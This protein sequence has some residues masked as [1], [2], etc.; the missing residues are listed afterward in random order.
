MSAATAI[1]GNTAGTLLTRFFGPGRADDRHAVETLRATADRDLR[2]RPDP[3][4]RGGKGRK[5]VTATLKAVH[6]MRPAP[7]GII[8]CSGAQSWAS[9]ST[10]LLRDREQ[11]G[12]TALF[13]DVLPARRRRASPVQFRNGRKEA[14]MS[15]RDSAKRRQRN[16]ARYH[17]RVA[18]RR[19]RGLCVKCGKRLPAPER[20]IC[21][22]C[23][24]KA[25][26]AERARAERLRAEGKPVR[27]PEARRRA[28]RERGRRQH[29][30]RR[31]AGLCVKCGRAPALP[32][33]SQCEPC[34][35]RRLAA[36]RARHARAR[37]EGRPRRDPESARRGERERGRQR[38]AE[39]RAAGV[40]IRCGNV[41][42]QE[43]RS[44]CEP[45]RDDRRAAKRARRA[46]R[47]AAGLCETCATPVTGGAACC[48]PLR[49]RPE[50]AAPARSGGGARG[51]PPALCRAARPGR[52]H[53]LRQAGQRGGPVSS[54]PR[55]P[56]APATTPAGPPG[57]ASSAARPPSAARPTARPA[58]PPRPGARTARPGTRPGAGTTP[59][60]GRRAAAS[61]AASR[62]RALHAA[63][64]APPSTQPSATV[65][66]R[67]PPGAGAMPNGGRG[68]AAS[69]AMRPR[70]V[71]RG[72]SPARSGTAR[73]RG[74][75]AASRCGTRAGR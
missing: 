16:L 51:R 15:D 31:A 66:R 19:E 61:V 21:V 7:S 44:M 45:C 49:R 26:A 4:P 40:C 25:R 36:D 32:E 42:P 34:A 28:D 64:P 57:S 60:G 56:R 22:S 62:P 1:P 47:R 38:R 53:E 35:A 39:R 43:G 5:A 27:D 71:R 46:A 23:G 17:R 75:S 6:K 63:G 12:L 59:N 20:S 24:E 55:A 13:P 48:R 69:S 33:R 72:A 52:L 74:R 30:E 10:G 9:P 68:D 50:R 11:K 2:R 3:N 70:P 8:A 29:A 73:A 37:A 54:L 14:V 65:R 41:P 67:T 58:P 18:E